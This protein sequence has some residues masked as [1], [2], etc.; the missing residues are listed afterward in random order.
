MFNGK[1]EPRHHR[2]WTISRLEE[3]KRRQKA[4][5]CA[6]KITNTLLRKLLYNTAFAESKFI[7]TAVTFTDFYYNW[8]GEKK[9]AEKM[10]LANKKGDYRMKKSFYVLSF[11]WASLSFG[12]KVEA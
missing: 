2:E 6:I 9:I 10:P 1:R 11:S 5:S 7:N 8:Q 12:E 4:L 3:W